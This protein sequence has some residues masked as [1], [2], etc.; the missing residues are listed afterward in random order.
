MQPSSFRLCCK[1]TISFLL[2]ARQS[3][4]S[5]DNVLLLRVVVVTPFAYL[6]LCPVASSADH[7]CRLI[8]E[9]TLS[10][11]RT[12]SHAKNISSC[13]FFSQYVLEVSEHF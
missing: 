6:V 12:L 7:M 1:Q 9:V 8:D 11:A 3:P 2:S 10:F 4:Y 5:I 13:L